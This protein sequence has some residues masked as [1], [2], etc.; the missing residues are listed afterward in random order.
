ML[1]RK[2]LVNP[3][4]W[5]EPRAGA[6]TGRAM[7]TGGAARSNTESGGGMRTATRSL[8]MGAYALKVD[9]KG[10]IAMPADIRRELDIDAFDG[11]VATPSVTDETLQCG[12]LDYLD[13]LQTMIEE[14]YE[15]FT[16]EAVALNRALLGQS[17]RIAFD[18]D[19]RF[20][21]PAPLRAHAGIED[22]VVLTGLGAT[23]EIRRGDGEE[24]LDA[25][26]RDLARKALTGLRR[27]HRNG[28]AA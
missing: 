16:P 6:G 7:R 22:R 26:T 1:S 14:R 18:G 23:F 28:G 5:D 4:L 3:G 10:R 12:G 19:G 25:A 2:V 15:P 24:T 21:L 20:I 8:F 13:S 27:P 11:F 9:A 17:R